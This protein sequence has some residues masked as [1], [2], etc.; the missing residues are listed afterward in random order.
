MFHERRTPL[1]GDAVDDGVVGRDRGLEF[2]DLRS[3]QDPVLLKWLTIASPPTG[4]TVVE[5]ARRDPVTLAINGPALSRTRSPAVRGPSAPSS[6]TGFSREERLTV[7]AGNVVK[8]GIVVTSGALKRTS[9]RVGCTRGDT[10]HSQWC[11]WR[12]T[13]RARNGEVPEP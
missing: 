5:A 4:S 11:T 2:R 8:W 10:V 3:A 12:R 7:K 9:F 1:R 13:W 6:G